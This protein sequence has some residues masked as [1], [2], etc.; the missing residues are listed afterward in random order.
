[1]ANHVQEVVNSH[2]MGG[3]V[4]TQD[5]LR[6]AYEKIS[7]AL[8]RDTRKYGN[9]VTSALETARILGGTSIPE[10]LMEA[11]AVLGRPGRYV[12]PDMLLATFP[13]TERLIGKPGS[14]TEDGYLFDILDRYKIPVKNEISGSSGGGG[15]SGRGGGSGSS[16]GGSSKREREQNT[17]A[18]VRA[19]D[20]DNMFVC[21]DWLDLEQK[22]PGAR[23]CSR[24]NCRFEHVY[25]SSKTPKLSTAAAEPAPAS[26][27]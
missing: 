25:H 8:Q 19:F 12:V 15:S 7:V 26:S 9:S 18:P 10:M 24:G 17:R 4:Y 21:Y 14:A 11:D 16:G 27:G 23:G 20:R 6:I 1:M 3:S 2:L 5:G 22:V 13:E